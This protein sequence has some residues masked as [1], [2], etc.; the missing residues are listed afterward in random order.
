MGGPRALSVVLRFRGRA[1]GARSRAPQP[2]VSRLALPR[3]ARDLCLRA[4]RLARARA[5]GSCARPRLSPA[6]ARDPP[7]RDRAADSRAARRALH[8]RERRPCLRGQ[9]EGRG[10]AAASHRQSRRRA[11]GLAGECP[12][13][14]HLRDPPGTS[15]PTLPRAARA[16]ERHL[17]ARARAVSRPGRRARPRR[18]AD[19]AERHDL[20]IP[21]ATYRL[22][23]NAGFTF[24]DATAL[25]PYLASLGVS[26]VYCSPYFRARAG[27]THGYDV[28]DHKSFN[29]DIDQIVAVRAA[30]TR[31]EDN[32]TELQS[33]FEHEFRLMLI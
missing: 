4:P 16:L 32:K 14:R 33:R 21:R 11:C 28:V 22:Q 6:A 10:R 20:V 5:G 18:R 24:R 12:R 27:S 17:A 26:H 2:R 23:L 25:V 19:A 7:R 29:P 13:P 9:L 15:R 31:S 30:N 3:R 8:A 1:R